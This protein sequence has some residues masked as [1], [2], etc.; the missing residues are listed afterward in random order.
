MKG[1]NNE[2]MG[3]RLNL[4]TEELGELAQAVTRGKSREE[5]FEE[6]IDI[7]NCLTSTRLFGKSTKRS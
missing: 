3:F 2:D 1:T 6:N 7:L 4:M 5:I